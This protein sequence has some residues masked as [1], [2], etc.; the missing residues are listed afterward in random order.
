[1][2]ET[3]SDLRADI[4]VAHEQEVRG[5]TGRRRETFL[6]RHSGWAATEVASA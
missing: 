6:C 2:N 5:D 1:M 4:I 3:V